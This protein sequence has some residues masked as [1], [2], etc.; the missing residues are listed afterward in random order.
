MY[1]KP[2][3]T[4]TTFGNT[5]GSTQFGQNTS[6]AF[7]AKPAVNNV[8]GTS[9]FSTSTPS[10]GG[11]FGGSSSNTGTGL[12]SGSTTGFGQPSSTGSTGFAFGNPS[13]SGNLF[14][15]NTQTASG[16][17]F[18]SS[19]TSA[20]GTPRPTFGGFS[21]NTGTGLFGQQQQQQTT[22]LF[23]QTA[24][25]STGLFGSTGFSTTVGTTVKFNPPIGSDTMMKNGLSTNINTRHQCITCMKDYENKSLEELRLEDYVANRKG[26]QVTMG[27]FG[28]TGQTGLFTTPAS[29]TGFSFGTQNKPL[30]GGSSTSTFGTTG[31]TGLFGQSTQQQQST[32]LFGKP[33]GFGAPTTSTTSSFGGFGTSGGTS[34]FGQAN[35]QKTLFGQPSGTGL[36]GSTATSQPSVGFGTGSTFGSGFGANTQST[37]LFGAKPAGFGTTAGTTTSTFTFGGAGTGSGLFGQKPAES[38]FGMGSTGFSFGNAQNQ[39]TSMFGQN[40]PATGF[41]M[42]LGTGF[43]GTS[44]GSGLGTGTSTSLFGN[45]AANKPSFSFGGAGGG[46]TSTGFLFGQPATSS[47][48]NFGGLGTTPSLGSNPNALAVAQQQAQTQQQVLAMAVNSNPFGDS[49]LFRNI[50]KDSNKREEVLKPT[51]PS[52]QNAILCSSQ[53]KVS[54]L[55]V[56][57]I[58]PKPIQPVGNK[59]SLF[60]GLEDEDSGFANETFIPRRSLKKL[61]IKPK[62]SPENSGN[63]VSVMKS[64]Q[65]S[66]FGTND[67]SFLKTPQQNHNTQ[68]LTTPL[69]VDISDRGNTSVDQPAYNEEKNNSPITSSNQYYPSSVSMSVSGYSATFQPN[70]DDTIAALNSA[71]NKA[72]SRS[73]GIASS[74][75]QEDADQSNLSHSISLEED[76]SQNDDFS[77]E[78]SETATPH[79]A[80]IVLKRP[81]YYT[82]PSLEELATMTDEKGNCIVE[83]FTIGR[84][85]YGNVFFPGTTNVSGLNLDELVHFRRKEITVYPDDENKPPLGEG[86]NKKAQVTLDCVWPNDKN[87]HTPIKNPTRLKN[88]CYQEK[89]ERATARLGAKFIDYRPET[90]SWVFEVQH[91]SKYGLEESDEEVE[92][93]PPAQEKES[94][95]PVQQN[96]QIQQQ[97]Q[98]NGGLKKQAI[99]MQHIDEDDEMLD[100]TQQ[101]MPLEDIEEL[102]QMD[103]VYSPSEKLAHA[104]GVD[105]HRMQGMKVSFFQDEESVEEVEDKGDP[106]MSTHRS[107]YSDRN[108]YVSKKYTNGE[109]SSYGVSLIKTNLSHI[110]SPKPISLYDQYPVSTSLAP[111]QPEPLPLVDLLTHHPTLRSGVTDDSSIQMKKS[112]MRTKRTL[113]LV[114]LN[115]SLLNERHHLIADLGCFLGRSFRIGWGPEWTFSHLGH[116]IGSSTEQVKSKPTALGLLTSVKPAMPADSTLGLTIE[117]LK[118]SLSYTP[119]DNLVKQ[120]LLESLNIQ[121]EHSASTIE[122]GCPLFIPSLGVDSLHAHATLAETQTADVDLSHSD[123]ETFKQ[124]DHVWKLGVALW[125][126]IPGFNHESDDPNTYMHRLARRQALSRWLIATNSEIVQ[127]EIKED[128]SCGN[129]YL[130][131]IFSQLTNFQISKACEVAQN[132]SDHRL[133]LLLAQAGSSVTFREMLRKQLVNWHQFK[134]DAFINSRRLKIYALLAGAL[135]WQSSEV[136][137]NCC[138]E[139]NWRRALAVHLWYHCSPEA[140]VAQAVADYDKAFQGESNNEKYA[141]PPFP[142]YIENNIS[143]LWDIMKPEETYQ[144]YDT[145]YHLLKL[146]CDRSHRLDQLL[147]PTTSVSSHLDYRLS[148][149]LFAVLQALGYTHLP[150][151]ATAALHCNF[152][153]QLES[154]GMWEWAAF[155]LLHISHSAR[156]QACVK[157]L[158]MKHVSLDQDSENEDREMFLHTKLKIPKEWIYEAKAV[159]SRALG[160]PQNE[161][162]Y[163][164]MA[165]E[166]SRSHD[167]VISQLAADAIINEEYDYLKSFLQKMAVHDHNAEILDWAVGGQVFL[168]Y[169]EVS[170]AV[171]KVLQGK[172]STYDL[173]KL[174][175]EVLSL[176]NRICSLRCPTAKDR[177]CQAEMAKKTATLLRAVLFLQKAKSESREDKAA[178]RAPV[179][180]LAPYIVKLPM[181]EDYALQELRTLARSYM[182]DLTEG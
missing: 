73:L 80:G 140:G 1:G 41:G 147:S 180:L 135:V 40:K 34:L 97:V 48:F 160:N 49:P 59:I 71:N 134:T 171:D 82:I 162:W 72:T 45:P 103:E 54:P 35:Q 64:V 58:K 29:T 43:T 167:I 60:D 163:L 114:S 16:G 20:F 164:M 65:Q 179:H 99:S 61:V 123:S 144:L 47:T 153:A 126:N 101:T 76:E 128:K 142:P 161:A 26:G 121:L 174:Q 42:G 106:I 92:I 182:L 116:C 131:T 125:G 95:K 94:E 133:A 32:G 86:L 117:R 138:E 57:K 18:G 145:C 155:A 24:T 10:S 100:I 129:D 88:M 124:A 53:H 107:K 154:M 70:L 132:A 23:S 68:A 85:S 150:S 108:S 113:A 148:W 12:F 149:L 14:G 83:N 3:G 158:L 11:L 172:V 28:S 38:S 9:A 79:P 39:G 146:Y 118:M 165:G 110:D 51:N 27:G 173:E 120:N 31:T 2:F 44:F 111:L 141:K 170:Q 81:G 22:G 102:S 74:R 96:K 119:N 177:L 137:V 4:A 30:F 127:T 36:F 168:D 13:T 152:A 75:C 52:A 89:I 66:P 159:K 143:Q 176:C 151:H 21:S 62:T 122:D 55:P 5:F 33:V 67:S 15:G 136:Q 104:L 6:S 98:V 78:P 157:D 139:L 90:G 115:K 69:T 87:T 166:W 77:K 169:I 56:A 63:S 109:H 130:A 93:V 112:V 178:T 46:G 50:I 17:L 105:V 19:S 37:G 84:E 25:P 156:R 7:G 181:P 175:P 8:F 91:F